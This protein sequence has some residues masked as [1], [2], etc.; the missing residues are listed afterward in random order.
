MLPFRISTFLRSGT[1]HSWVVHVLPFME[2]QAL[3]DQFDLKTAIASTK[4]NPQPQESQPSALLCPSDQSQGAFYEHDRTNAPDTGKRSRFGKGNYAAFTSL[5]HVD[6]TN[7][8]GAMALLG[9][10]LAQVQDG[11]SNTL[12]VSEVRTRNLEDDERG[13]WA[14]AWTGASLISYDLH[15][16]NGLRTQ[17][18]DGFTPDPTYLGTGLA[19]VPNGFHPD[20]I[21]K[22]TDNVG[23][24]AIGMPCGDNTFFSASPRSNHQG[25]VNASFLDGHVGFLKNDID[26]LVMAYL[27]YIR[28]GQSVDTSSL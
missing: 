28:D 13:V 8:P 9:Q 25:G 7:F 15:P 18:E 10:D 3:Y 23:A 26:E 4:G 24:L 19:N 21:N 14:L 20:I 6:Y 12:L 5:T 17:E 27:I 11:T 16:L 2:Q 22:C 1:N